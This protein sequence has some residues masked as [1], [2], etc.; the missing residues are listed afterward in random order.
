MGNGTDIFGR[1]SLQYF[2]N[3]CHVDCCLFYQKPD[4][5]YFREFLPY[6]ANCVCVWICDRHYNLALYFYWLRHSI[7]CVLQKN[8]LHLNN[9]LFWKYP[10]TKLFIW[11]NLLKKNYFQTYLHDDPGIFQLR[12]IY[13]KICATNIGSME[14]MSLYGLHSSRKCMNQ[15][16]LIVQVTRE[17]DISL[18]SLLLLLILIIEKPRH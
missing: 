9:W 5:P 14:H 13:F 10:I 17:L 11:P 12:L 6:S 8:R 15:F 18:C 4:Q 3:A 7:K 2:L 16:H 1:D